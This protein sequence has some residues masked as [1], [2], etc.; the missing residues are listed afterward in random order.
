MFAMCVTSDK[1]IKTKTWKIDSAC[2]EHINHCKDILRN[3]KKID[4]GVDIANQSESKAVGMGDI[5][6]KVCDENGGIIIKLSKVMHCPDFGSNL[7]SIRQ[8]DKKGYELRIGDSQV[9]IHYKIGPVIKGYVRG[10]MYLFDVDRTHLKSTQAAVSQDTKGKE[11]KED[12]KD[13]KEEI[14]MQVQAKLV[15]VNVWHQRFAHAKNL[16]VSDVVGEANLK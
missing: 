3:Y 2:N 7:L 13:K 14:R 8:L 1:A 15:K 12:T 9:V 11:E 5:V 6:M 16:P 4:V 10:D